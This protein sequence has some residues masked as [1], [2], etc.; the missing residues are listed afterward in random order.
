MRR[1]GYVFHFFK[2]LT[3][4]QHQDFRALVF[5]FRIILIPG[6]RKESLLKGVFLS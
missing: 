1:N 6:I 4:M 5:D 3:Y 2:C